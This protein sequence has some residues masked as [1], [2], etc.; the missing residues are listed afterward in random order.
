MFYWLTATKVGIAS[1]YF[2]VFGVVH[3][4]VNEIQHV[5]RTR[6]SYDRA[7]YVPA[8]GSSRGGLSSRHTARA[9]ANRVRTRDVI[10]ELWQ[11]QLKART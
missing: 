7:R 5:L 1:G 10:I 9:H 11:H 3:S 8:A 4:V 6:L 2:V